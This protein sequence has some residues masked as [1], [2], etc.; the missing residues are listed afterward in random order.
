MWN[1]V[2]KIFKNKIALVI[3][4]AIIAVAGY[5]GYG[6]FFKG[7][8]TTVNYTTAT[9]QRG[10]LIS[11][12]SGSGQV[13]ASN[14]VDIKAKAAGDVLTVNVVAG[15]KVNE[16]D[17]LVK[18]D[19]SDA[20]KTV[21]DAQLSLDSAK[22][23][24]EKLQ[25]PADSLTLL[26]DGNAVTQAQQSKQN[27]QDDLTKAYDSGLNSVSSTFLDL[28]TIVTGLNDILYGSNSVVVQSNINYINYYAD[29]VKDLNGK[30][31]QYR[32]D[33][34]STYNKLRADYDKNFQ[35]YKTVSR[36]ANAADVENLINETYNTAR[37]AADAVK[38]AN[39][40]IQLYKDELSQ[41]NLRT[42][43]FADTHL[44]TLSGY[45]A[46]TNSEVSDL[47][48]VKNTI[49]NSEQ[50]IADSDQTI[51]EKQ[52]A[53][54]KLKAGADA[55]DLKSQ[56][57]S[58]TQ[59]ENALSDAQDK[60]ADYTVKAPFSGT[61][62]SVSAKTGDAA[63]SSG[64]LMTIIS[65]QQI[66]DI[67]LNE[68]DVSKAKVGQKATL[69]FDA[70]G[71]LTIT[72]KV[73]QIDTIGTVSQGVVSYTA[74]IALDTQDDRIKPGMSVTAT[75]ITEA[76]PDVLMVPNAAVKSNNNGYYVQTVTGKDDTAP[77]NQT[78]EIG[79]ANDTY[80]EITSGLNEGDTVVTASTT[81]TAAKPST[82]SST[83]G[84]M[85]GGG[86]G[87]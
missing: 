7:G 1:P 2:K 36:S 67:S 22:L 33:A 46:K 19:D 66:A 11:S 81:S 54:D 44:A 43:P 28:P 47:F 8:K 52:M 62:A 78:V 73:S 65:N 59:R 32:N 9:A 12:V 70:V 35:D 45:T 38:A 50:T 53:L 6:Y 80:T 58:V 61:V 69:I 79:T 55:N 68:V 84:F 75:V 10:T 41:R 40:L 25:E 30:A 49:Q 29:S 34:S 21:R 4:V 87:R 82:T 63:A 71:G 48:S 26:Q 18:L 24:L 72:G 15:Q 42:Q 13:S 74:E 60:L 57:L 56:Q 27:A 77:K 85:L 14:Q 64:A 37:D 23:Q 5:Y 31:V 16:G 3:V 76:K 20:Q 39:N 51:T 83:R 86:G 17:V